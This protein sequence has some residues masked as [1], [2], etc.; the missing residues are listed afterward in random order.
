MH[1]DYRWPIE[2]WLSDSQ[3]WNVTD[4]RTHLT[5]EHEVILTLKKVPCWTRPN[6]NIANIAQ[7]SKNETI[8]L[9]Y[10]PNTQASKHSLHYEPRTTSGVHLRTMSLSSCAGKWLLARPVSWTSVIE[11][12][13]EWLIDQ[14]T[15][16]CPWPNYRESTDFDKIGH[17]LRLKQRHDKTDRLT[18]RHSCPHEENTL[19]MRE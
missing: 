17:L 9:T 11:L 7:S 6:M 19:S 3:K 1:P 16:F 8:I 5:S 12:L 4:R 15:E 18:D 14:L 10:G 2:L 13:T